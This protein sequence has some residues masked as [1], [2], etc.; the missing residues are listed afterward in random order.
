MNIKEIIQSIFIYFDLKIIRINNDRK[1]IDGIFKFIYN[2]DK[3]DLKNFLKPIRNKI[4]KKITIIDVGAN[5]GQSIIRFKAI[6]PKSIIYSYEPINAF[7]EVLKKNFSTNNIILNNKAVGSK[8]QKKFINEYPFGASS[9]FKLNFQV[10]SIKKRYCKLI[11]EQPRIYKRQ[12]TTVTTIDKEYKIKNFKKINILKIDTQGF[13]AEVLKGATICLKNS[14]IDFIQIEVI[15]GATYKQ[16]YI[17]DVDTILK[18]Y[19]YFLLCVEPKGHNLLNNCEYH[20]ELLYCN[21]LMLK[22]IEK[23]HSLK[24]YRQFI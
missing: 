13:E 10:P 6:S 12:E 22:K 9:F 16:C 5:I 23:F 8:I 7:F 14:L 1:S 20:V 2:K 4:F 18:K 17:S 19:N 15:L 21:N 3:K 24:D 11:K